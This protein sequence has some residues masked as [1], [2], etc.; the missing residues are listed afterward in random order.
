MGGSWLRLT[1]CRALI[2]RHY[3]GLMPARFHDPGLWNLAQGGPEAQL[4]PGLTRG[5]YSTSSPSNPV[6]L[7]VYLAF[8]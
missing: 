8:F 1:T 3:Q 6:S 7:R 2:H 4:A 5:A